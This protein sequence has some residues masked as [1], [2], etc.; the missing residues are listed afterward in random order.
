MRKGLIGIALAVAFFSF[1]CTSVATASTETELAGLRIRDSFS[2]WET[3][4]GDYGRW[5]GLNWA[6][7]GEYKTGSVNTGGWS[8]YGG[9]T[10][11][12]WKTQTFSDSGLGDAASVTLT[13]SPTETGSYG[14]VWL[15]MSTPGSAKSGYQLSWTL[16]SA[17]GSVY[18][19]KL[20]KWVSGVQTALASNAAV[21]LPVG[22]TLTIFDNGGTVSGWKGSGGTLAS[23]LSASD[24]TFSSG[25]AGVEGAKSSYVQDFRAGNLPGPGTAMP[26]VD[27]LS[28]AE[29]PLSNGGK[30][31]AL[32][33]DS[34]TSNRTGN[35]TAEGWTPADAFPNVNGAYWSPTSLSD[36]G[37][38]DAV[39]VTLKPPPA[40]EELYASVWL[41][42]PS[43]GTAKSGYQLI[44]TRNSW[45]TGS[46][47]AKI[48]KWVSG[49]PTPLFT[50]GWASILSPTTIALVDNGATLTAYTGTPEYLYRM[51]SVA[52]STYSSG[53]AG[54]EGS[55]SGSAGARLLNFRLGAIAAVATAPKAPTVT[56]MYP[57]SPSSEDTVYVFGT[58]DEES[59]VSFYPNSACSGAALPVG[60]GDAAAFSTSGIGV[61]V[62]SNATTTIYAKATNS[63]GSSPCSTSSVTYVE[64]STAPAA[65]TVSATDPVSPYKDNSPK[66]RG[67]AEAGS[68]VKLYTNSTCTGTVAASGGASSFAS[69]GIPVSVSDNT[70]TTFW[71][72]ATD[73]AGNVSSCS[74]TSV[75]Y[76]ELSP[77]FY[78]GARLKR[79]DPEKPGHTIQS[80]FTPSVQTDYEEKEAGK[81]ASIVHWFSP[82]EAAAFCGEK[83]PYCEFQ[84]GAYEW[85]RDTHDSIPMISWSPEFQSWDEVGPYP[86]DSRIAALG[87]KDEYIRSWAKA[88]KAWGHP[89]FLRF[90]WEMN[91]KWFDWGVGE[92]HW[93]ET[94]ITWT[95]TAS[96]F[97]EMW[98][99]VHGIFKEEGVTNATWVWCPNIGSSLST[100]S[101][102]YPGDAYVDW[103]CL[104]GYNGNDGGSPTYRSFASLFESSYASIAGSIAPNKPMMIGETA[105]TET[106]GSKSEWITNMFNSLP[107]KFPKIHA[108]VWFDAKEP[109][110]GGKEDWPISSSASA[111][112]AFANGLKNSLSAPA[113]YGDLN[114]S[115]IPATP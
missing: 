72:T 106:G 15:N 39:A 6:E 100:L 67:S 56:G 66:V 111:I 53:Y 3:P 88:A 18:T 69:P 79:P 20:S 17:G 114:T 30:W 32:A 110:P 59:T 112:T 96:D 90:A 86:S 58:A 85:V 87:I 93:K 75:T 9:V 35:D 37:S 52:D 7:G 42:M 95:N 54:I 63:A 44:W 43:P 46:M 57:T 102:L 55:G 107:T 26:V 36:S 104:D 81:T 21:S 19:A 14:S 83:E 99:H 68:T 41:N 70:T 49:T 109:G 65:P 16:N 12:Y 92:H 78:W 29:A 4:L 5:G 113:W 115:P 64:D 89:F 80:P 77:T 105:S 45:I 11:A 23:F 91:G 38:G 60:G 50:W 10:G 82:W 94:S 51:F 74:T 2:R 76:K 71:A 61:Q 1:V 108:L 62:P 98:K 34:A 101:S 47:N 24:S 27:G 13:G 31:K 28:R 25:Y 33:W 103:T 97:V 48:V 73:A 8:P 22:T 84:K 40:T